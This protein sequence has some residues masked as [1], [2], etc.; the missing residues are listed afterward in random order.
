MAFEGE[1]SNGSFLGFWL[2]DL[3]GRWRHSIRNAG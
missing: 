3:G 2:E 1:R